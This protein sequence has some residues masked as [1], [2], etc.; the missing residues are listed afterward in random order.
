VLSKCSAWEENLRCSTDANVS[1][2]SGLG[3]QT[4]FANLPDEAKRSLFEL[5]N[6]NFDQ[7]AVSAP[8]RAEALFIHGY[9]YTMPDGRPVF[10]APFGWDFHL[11]MVAT[12]L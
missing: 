4:T 5:S 12:R 9:D 11:S 8:D 2:S 6:R 10:K 7:R 1:S 3:L